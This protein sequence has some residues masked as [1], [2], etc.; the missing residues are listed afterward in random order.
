SRGVEGGAGVAAALRGGGKLPRVGRIGPEEREQR[1]AE[2]RGVRGGG[3]PCVFRLGHVSN[4][5]GGSPAGRAH[6]PMYDAA[7]DV[8]QGKERRVGKE[9]GLLPLVLFALPPADT[10]EV[11]F[12]QRTTTV[13]PG[14]G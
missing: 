5:V 4:G 2:G 7:S 3:A 1:L 14:R 11:G 13:T 6:Q 12:W 9:T 8:V 10:H